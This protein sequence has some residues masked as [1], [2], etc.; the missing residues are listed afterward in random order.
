MT[1]DGAKYIDKDHV[2]PNDAQND[3]LRD[4]SVT[5][6]KVSSDKRSRERGLPSLDDHDPITACIPPSISLI[7]YLSPASCLTPKLYLSCK[8]CSAA[9]TK[10]SPNLQ[11]F[12][13]SKAKMEA[14]YL[15]RACCACC[16]CCALILSIIAVDLAIQRA[17]ASSA[18]SCSASQ[19]LR[20]WVALAL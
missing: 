12:P 19:F 13:T 20:L 5:S 3:D 17:R 8:T 14:R 9:I 18:V 6:P 1:H 7:Y 10:F 15:L 4:L 11:P 2:N 16:A